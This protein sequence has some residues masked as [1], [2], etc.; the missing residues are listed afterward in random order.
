MAVLVFV[1]RGGPRLFEVRE[2]GSEVSASVLVDPWLD[3]VVARLRHVRAHGLPH[4]LG[5]VVNPRDLR[6]LFVCRTGGSGC[7]VPEVVLFL[8]VVLRTS[9]EAL[10]MP[11]A[12]HSA[13]AAHSQ[14]P[15]EIHRRSGLLDM[16]AV[17]GCRPLVAPE[18]PHRRVIS[19]RLCSED[20][21]Q[22]AAIMLL[23]LVEADAYVER[24]VVF[25]HP[26]VLHDFEDRLRQS[27]RSSFLLHTVHEGW[28]IE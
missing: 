6:G 20:T 16:Q 2:V 15:R 25:C 18:L 10:R 14:L 5:L 1:I 23:L 4:D 17:H 24:L 27:K 26:A 12:G 9:L 28:Q 21:L 22:A 3:D 7:S 8:G 11:A 19:L 13:R